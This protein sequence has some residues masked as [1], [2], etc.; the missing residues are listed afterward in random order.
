[1]EPTLFDK[2]KKPMLVYKDLALLV[3]PDAA[4]FLQQVHFWLSVYVNKDDKSHYIQGR[5]W[6][7]NSYPQWQKQI[8][9]MTVKILRRITGELRELNLLKV[10]RGRGGGP[11]WYT[12]D[13]DVLKE[14]MYGESDHINTPEPAP[15]G[16]RPA[17]RGRRSIRSK[18]RPSLQRI[19]TERTQKAGTSPASQVVP[20]D[21][22]DVIDMFPIRH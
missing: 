15:Q 7:W 6:I 14:L 11:L 4:L 13:Y 18:G 5:W 1:M 22:D 8:P 9:W 10:M 20:P 12:V 19:T 16:R 2:T 21:S 3:G 17:P